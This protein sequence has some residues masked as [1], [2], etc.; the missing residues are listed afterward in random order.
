MSAKKGGGNKGRKDGRKEEKKEEKN[1]RRKLTAV[2]RREKSRSRPRWKQ[3]VEKK[4]GKKGLQSVWQSEHEGNR[5]DL[6]PLPVRKHFDPSV[7][8]QI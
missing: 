1:T 4:S 3:I 2:V 6:R 5:V 7:K 8:T